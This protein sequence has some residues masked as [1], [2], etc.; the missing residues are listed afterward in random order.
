MTYRILLSINKFGNKITGGFVQL[1]VRA[2]EIERAFGI[3]S[4][5]NLRAAPFAAPFATVLLWNTLLN[6]VLKRR[7]GVY[8]L[9]N[10]FYVLRKCILIKLSKIYWFILF[11]SKCFKAWISN[12]PVE[13][14]A[15]L[16]PQKL[17]YTKNLMTYFTENHE[18]VINLKLGLH[19]I[20][21]QL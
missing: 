11:R 6:Q 18:M 20:V 4:E 16:D 17:T 9:L 5:S 1:I 2:S 12:M 15:P 3:K 8:V 10:S 21:I 19:I 14:Q 7:P 13:Q